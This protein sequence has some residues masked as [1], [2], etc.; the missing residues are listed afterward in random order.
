MLHT[1]SY[2]TEMCR[3][4]LYFQLVGSV[5]S[6]YTVLEPFRGKD[7]Q[8]VHPSTITAHLSSPP[9]PLSSSFSTITQLLSSGQFIH[10]GW[11]E[12]DTKPNLSVKLVLGL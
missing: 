4:Y 10:T 5:D 8:Q 6:K 1:T 9:P 2:S 11:G 3:H 12:R 7:D